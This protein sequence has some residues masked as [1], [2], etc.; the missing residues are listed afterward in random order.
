MNDMNDT[1]LTEIILKLDEKTIS[2]LTD[3]VR[4][5]RYNPNILSN[6]FS[7]KFLIRLTT[8]LAKKNKFEIFKVK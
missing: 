8:A 1:N 6:S 5:K 2:Y 4:K 3:E 7:D